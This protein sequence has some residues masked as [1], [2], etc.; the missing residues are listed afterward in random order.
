VKA[1]VQAQSGKLVAI[2]CEGEEDALLD[3]DTVA[4]RFAGGKAVFAIELVGRQLVGST[5]LRAAHCASLRVVTA[6]TPG[7][8][9]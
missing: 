2:F 5:C 6:R 3:A 9:Y 1:R 8:V 4:E 7:C